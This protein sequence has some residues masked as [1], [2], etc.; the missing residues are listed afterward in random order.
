MCTPLAVLDTCE[1]FAELKQKK[2]KNYQRQ[3]RVQLICLFRQMFIPVNIKHNTSSSRNMRAVIL[4]PEKGWLETFRRWGWGENKRDAEA[5]NG[6]FKKPAT[7]IKLLLAAIYLQQL[8]NVR[9]RS[10]RS[11]SA[12]PA[13]RSPGC[14]LER[15]I[16]GHAGRRGGEEEEYNCTEV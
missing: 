15:G 14:E 5:A 6:I 7:R 12:P 4:P 9:T 10:N 1:L 2:K 16:K 13:A 3:N 11:R 8:L